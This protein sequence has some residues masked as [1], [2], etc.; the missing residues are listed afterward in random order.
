MIIL[1]SDTVFKERAIYQK[2]L[3]HRISFYRNHTSEA[4]G[5]DGDGGDRRRRKRKNG[6]EDATSKDDFC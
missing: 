1:L 5:V 4:H 3:H 2:K 6:E